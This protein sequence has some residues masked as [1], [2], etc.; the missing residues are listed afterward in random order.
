MK[1]ILLTQ[2]GRKLRTVANALKEGV[3]SVGMRENRDKQ[4]LN[5]KLIKTLR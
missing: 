1:W 4:A 2:K 3:S 5:N